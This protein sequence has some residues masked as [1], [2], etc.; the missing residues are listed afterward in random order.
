NNWHLKAVPSSSTLSW[1]RWTT[2]EA[3]KDVCAIATF[4]TAAADAEPQNAVILPE[5]SVAM[6]FVWF[7]ARYAYVL[8]AFDEDLRDIRLAAVDSE[9]DEVE[10]VVQTMGFPF[11]EDRDFVSV[12]G[13]ISYSRET[14]VGYFSA[15]GCIFAFQ[16]KAAVGGLLL[17]GAGLLD[18]VSPVIS[19]DG[20]ILDFYATSPG[21]ED[22]FACAY[23]RQADSFHV[24]RDRR[25]PVM[26]ADVAFLFF[27]H[28]FFFEGSYSTDLASF[29]KLVSIENGDRQVLVKVD[30][31]TV[32]LSRGAGNSF[33]GVSNKGFYH[34]RITDLRFDSGFR[35]KHWRAPKVV[36]A[37]YPDLSTPAA[38]I[39]TFMASFQK[40]DT[41][42]WSICHADKAAK[43]WLAAVTKGVAARSLKMIG[44][45]RTYT[46]F[47]RS[48]GGSEIAV[49]E[50][51]LQMFGDIIGTDVVKMRRLGGL[52]LI[53]KIA[54]EKNPAET[55]PQ[56]DSRPSE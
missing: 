26:Y 3:G 45:L 20:G 37:K 22:Y 44:D 36:T 43:T 28:Q 1:L 19:D 40:A 18:L 41:N 54:A 9:T 15:L 35:V 16:G 24:Y 52:W 6:D 46:T 49:L 23:D 34:Y 11:L 32:A 56:D 29:G 27:H 30:K 53:E 31:G 51:E 39:R 50:G 48:V 33:Y 38:T 17:D 2:D 25:V 5:N 55:P 14:D 47:R 13:S 21:C 7:D 10:Y 8:L 12:P 4:D 42:V